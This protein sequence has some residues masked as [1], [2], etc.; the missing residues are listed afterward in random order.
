MSGYHAA[1]MRSDVQVDAAT[2]TRI[3][4]RCMDAD[5]TVTSVRRLHGGMINAVYR[6][7]TAGDAPDLAV[8]LAA[9][10]YEDFEAQFRMLRWFAEH[11]ELPTP[12]VY[13]HLD[14]VEELSGDG[15]VRGL[16][17]QCVSG[18]N[19]GEAQLTRRGIEHFQA[20]LARHLALLHEHHREHYG[21]ALAGEQ[22]ERWCDWFAPKIQ[23]NYEKAADQ[24]SPAARQTTEK[25]LADLDGWLGECS[26]PTLVHGDIW[27]TNIMVD[28]A[29]PNR[30]VITAF[31]DNAPVLFADV[32]YEL[33]YLL[34]FHT[35]DQTFFD[36]YT[37]QHPLRDGFQ[38][39]RLVYWLN[40]LALHVWHHGPEYI[41][42]TERIAAQIAKC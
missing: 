37:Q 27:A 15:Q 31:I 1:V 28:D 33:A 20:D 29:D 4:R 34:V 12:E 16:I 2:A 19:F 21:S 23:F 17:M 38:Q 35:A 32:E 40:T 36:H 8:K 10:Q 41:P 11:T 6:W 22:F 25:L 13:A 14:H 7:D 39:R 5:L 30:P 42:A 3:V 24:L 9:H 26:P 18:R